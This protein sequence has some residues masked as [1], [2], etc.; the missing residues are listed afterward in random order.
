M[1][2]QMTYVEQRIVC[3]LQSLMGKMSVDKISVSLLCATAEVGRSSFYRYF[4]S[5]ED[6]YGYT[7][8]GWIGP[9]NELTAKQIL[10]RWLTFFKNHPSFLNDHSYLSS[11][12]MNSRWIANVVG[13]LKSLFETDDKI[14]TFVVHIFAGGLM[15]LTY[16]WI[17]SCSE[18]VEVVSDFILDFFK[19]PSNMVLVVKP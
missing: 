1:N 14:N 12:L 15:N 2:I 13:Q 3:A 4:S 19:I 6:V 8:V 9:E 5:V 10:I 18:T 16:Q 17:Q 7:I 11:Y